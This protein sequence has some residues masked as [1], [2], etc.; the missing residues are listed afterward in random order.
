M[1]TLDRALQFKN[2]HTLFQMIQQYG[3]NN[4]IKLSASKNYKLPTLSLSRLAE[5]STGN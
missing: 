3:H 2:K 5:Y 1:N 4:E